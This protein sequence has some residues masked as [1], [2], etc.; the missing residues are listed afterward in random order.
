MKYFNNYPAYI[1]ISIDVLPGVRCVVSS[2]K[3]VIWTGNVGN[4]CDKN[5]VDSLF[6]PGKFKNQMT[7]V[8]S[9]SISYFFQMSNFFL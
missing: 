3:L 6:T 8:L 9:K 5:N 2:N 4:S 7:F 1:T